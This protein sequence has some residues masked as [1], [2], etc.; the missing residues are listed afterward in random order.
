M[1]Y[2]APEETTSAVSTE[3]TTADEQA[4]GPSGSES[5]QPDAGAPS[6]ANATK[7]PANPTEIG[8]ISVGGTALP[9][10]QQGKDDPAVGQAFPP[11]S[12]QSLIDGSPLK[13]A[14]DGKAKLVLFVAHWCPHCQAE[15]PL[16]KA[17]LDKNPPAAGVEV[18]AISTSVSSEK[19]NY[20][21][22]GVAGQGGWTYPTLSDDEA[23]TALTAA[24][25][26]GFPFF[27]AVDRDGNVAKRASGE[28]DE[29]ELGQLMKAL[30]NG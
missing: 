3:L 5:T 22:V 4:S 21:A 17:Y 30:A 24:G 8:A 29:K 9:R 26:S 6:T 7:G 14:N 23:N 11:I 12:G 20:P 25:A 15:V 18:Y 19:N 13:I 2:W 27:V 28:L 16:V 1:P 10:L